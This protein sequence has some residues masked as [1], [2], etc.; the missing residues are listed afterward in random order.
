MSDEPN[1][2]TAVPP[3]ELSNTHATVNKGT[4]RD[5]APG[6]LMFS[7]EIRGHYANCAVKEF[8][9]I[10][11]PL[12]DQLNKWAEELGVGFLVVDVKYAPPNMLVTYTLTLDDDDIDEM[13]EHQEEIDRVLRASRARKAEKKRAD[14]EAAQ[15]VHEEEN[16]LIALGKR[17]RDN[18]SKKGDS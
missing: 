15:K 14:E 2:L 17:C 11:G 8:K 16:A 18:H 4:L 1:A 5:R 9:A 10:H 7:G 12:D 3:T 13:N 6:H